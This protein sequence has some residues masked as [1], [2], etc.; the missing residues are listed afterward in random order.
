MILFI[1]SQGQSLGSQGGR[2]TV[3]NFHLTYLFDMMWSVRSGHLIKHQ[4][5]PSAVVERYLQKSVKEDSA[6][7]I[8]HKWESHRGLQCKPVQS[9]NCF[10]STDKSGVVRISPN[11]VFPAVF[12]LHHVHS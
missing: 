7:T 6:G 12:G 9:T 10:P 5:I 4:G 3:I 11:L 8:Q 2:L 1:N